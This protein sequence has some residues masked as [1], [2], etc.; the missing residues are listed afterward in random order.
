VDHSDTRAGADSVFWIVP[1]ILD[2]KPIK[3]PNIFK[4]FFNYTFSFRRKEE[5]LLCSK[6]ERKEDALLCSKKRGKEDALL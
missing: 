3:E 5:A 1:V 4:P 6:K 2:P